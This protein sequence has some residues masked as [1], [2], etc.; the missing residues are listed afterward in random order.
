M[1]ILSPEMLNHIPPCKL[2]QMFY[3]YYLQG[4]SCSGAI[5]ILVIAMVRNRV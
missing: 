5:T 1:G 3:L 4:L 2:C